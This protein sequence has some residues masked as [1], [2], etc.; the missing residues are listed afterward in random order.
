V[1]APELDEESQYWWC[2]C[3]LQTPEHVLEITPEHVLEIRPERK[4]RGKILWAEVQK[5]TGRRKVRF[6]IRDQ[7]ADRGRSQLELGYLSTTDAE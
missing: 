6:I 4:A 2:S 7:L 3:M 1:L 5:G